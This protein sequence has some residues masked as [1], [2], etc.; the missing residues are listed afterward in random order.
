MVEEEEESDIHIRKHIC[1]S[2]GQDIPILQTRFE[3]E[4][5]ISLGHLR[6]ITYRSFLT[7][8]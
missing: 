6:P 1:R 8:T 3:V 4:L 2:R 7:P 5:A